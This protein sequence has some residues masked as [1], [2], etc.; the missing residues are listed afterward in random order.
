MSRKEELNKFVASKI[1]SL[2]AQA[3][4]GPGKSALAALRKG[5]GKKPGEIPQIFGTVMEGMPEV[6]LSKDGNPTKEEWAC[7][8]VLTMFAW[9]QQGY[10]LEKELMHTEQTVSLGYAA[11]LLKE[12]SADSNSNERTLKKLQVI[13]LSDD[14]QSLAVHLRSFISLL[15]SEKIKLNYALLAS[16]I[17]D[18]QF[19]ESRNNV[20]LKWGQDYYKQIREDKVNE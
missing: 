7:Y 4:T 18:W 12:K 13:M 10:N 19:N 16:D 17:Y 1:Y 20:N 3:D 5:V 15:A 8:I 9:H 2:K 6:F 14:I 11:R